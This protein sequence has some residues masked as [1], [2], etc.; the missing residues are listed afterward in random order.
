MAVPA[1]SRWWIATLV[2]VGVLLAISALALDRPNVVWHAHSPQ[3]PSCRT[4][5]E[6]YSSRCAT[7]SAEFDWIVSGD[8]QSPLSNASL[9]V[10]ETEWLRKRVAELGVE[11][12]AERVAEKTGLSREA[13]L[14]YLTVGHGNCGWCGGTRKDLASPDLNE[15]ESCPMCL[16][17]G[18]SI[19]CGG[20][21]RVTLGNWA[22]ERALTD[23]KAEMRQLTT[24]N[25]EPDV[26]QDEARRLAE[27]FLRRFAGTQQVESI[28]FW[29]LVA[30]RTQPSDETR[31]VRVGRR[32][33]DNVLV[34]LRPA[35]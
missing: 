18:R 34:S 5:V 14:E 4:G 33:L 26:V 28:Y 12:A 10:L 23:Y 29:P 25:L 3:C 24:A 32:R 16:G 13:A 1:G 35:E 19:A 30:P 9:S 21:R 31:A 11:N 20:D 2:I 17:T 7:C 8:E 15:P 27:G 22:A 6:W